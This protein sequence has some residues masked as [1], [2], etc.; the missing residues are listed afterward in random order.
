MSIKDRPGRNISV[1]G[2]CL[3]LA[4]PFF[5]PPILGGTG[6]I[7]GIIGTVRSQDRTL[8]ILAIIASIVCAGFGTMFLCTGGGLI[9]CLLWGD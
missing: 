6:L 5:L 9:P 8:G 7:C 2:L 3:A 1:A 4:S